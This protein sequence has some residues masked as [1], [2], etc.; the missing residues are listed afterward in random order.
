MFK[1]IARTVTT[2]FIFFKQ[3]LQVQ[4]F[5]FCHLSNTSEKSKSSPLPECDLIVKIVRTA[6]WAQMNLKLS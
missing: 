1:E 3:L 2:S 5:T 4:Y 6:F